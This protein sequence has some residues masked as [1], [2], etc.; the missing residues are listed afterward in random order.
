[1]GKLKHCT[2]VRKAAKVQLVAT[3]V[4]EIQVNATKVVGAIANRVPSGSIKNVDST[5]I[6]FANFKKDEI[7]QP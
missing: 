4:K 5:C 6:G 3:I 2:Q 1:M 7:T